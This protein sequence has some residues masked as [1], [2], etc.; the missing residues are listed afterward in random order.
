MHDY[1]S[2]QLKMPKE[3][4]EAVRRFQSGIS[5]MSLNIK[6]GGLEDRPHVTI[7]YGLEGRR[8]EDIKKIFEEFGPITVWLGKVKAFLASET[9]KPADVIYVEVIG[10]EIDMLH[11]LVSAHLPSVSTNPF[12]RPHMTLAFLN[13]GDATEYVENNRFEGMNA[14]VESIEFSDVNENIKNIKLVEERIIEGRVYARVP[15]GSRGLSGG[16]A[17]ACGYRIR[18]GKGWVPKGKLKAL[19]KLMKELNAEFGNGN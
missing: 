6:E 7:L 8:V 1:Q 11:L 14:V 16:I 18:D 2:V 17:A 19:L 9:R 10:R 13:P 5:N 4:T 12:F 3:I 15:E